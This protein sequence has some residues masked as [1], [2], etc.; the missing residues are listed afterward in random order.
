MELLFNLDL[1]APMP[2]NLVLAVGLNGTTSQV[3]ATATLL[4]R[5]WTNLGGRIVGTGDT[6]HVIEPVDRPEE[7]YQLISFP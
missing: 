2:T 7:F 6:N 5:A 4:Y 1:L 3:P